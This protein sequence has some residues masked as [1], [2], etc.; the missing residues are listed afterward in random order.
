[1]QAPPLFPDLR[2]QEIH[3]RLLAFYGQP[4]ERE[5]W[6][7]LKQ[8]VYSLL[9]SRT[10]TEVS[11]AVMRSLEARFGSWEKVRDASVSE[12]EDAIRAI[13]F[14]EKKAVQLKQA[15][16]Q[17]T[18]R[19]GTLS[20]DFLRTY[21]TEKI[22]AWLEGFEGV[23]VKTSAAVVNFSTLRRRA[24]CVDSHHL[25]VTQRLGFVSRNADARQTEQRLMEMAPAEWSP[26]MLDEHHSLIKIHGQQICT[27]SQPRCPACPL[28]DTCPT[29]AHQ[30]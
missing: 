18:H 6:D 30:R 20:L 24:M 21:R 5:L 16:E 11:H 10:R 14:P 28:L 9:S 19:C 2:L 12:I 17:I 23:G 27:F 1:M 15:L 29:G 7:P 3:R 4:A 8:F 26:A 25:R 13:T 22:R